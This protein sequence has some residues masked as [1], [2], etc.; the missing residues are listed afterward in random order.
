MKFSV[1]SFLV[2]LLSFFLVGCFEKKQTEDT[3]TNLWVSSG[4]LNE[5]S[6]PTS[7]SQ[8]S[9]AELSDTQSGAQQDLVELQSPSENTNSSPSQTGSYTPEEQEAIVLETQEELEDL[10]NNLMQ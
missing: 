5:V 1:I 7:V 10:F 8:E 6:S 2:L 3:P 9:Q 4:T